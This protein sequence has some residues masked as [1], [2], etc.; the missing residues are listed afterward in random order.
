MI[1]V[2]FRKRWHL[3]LDSTF[4]RRGDAG[5][6]NGEMVQVRSFIAMRIVTM[7]LGTTH[8]EELVSLFR[9]FRRARYFR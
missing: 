1:V 7:T 2:S 4:D 6:A 3:T 5:I 9:E 8:F